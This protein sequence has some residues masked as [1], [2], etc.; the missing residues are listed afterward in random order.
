[1]FDMSKA[2]I[3]TDE[4][5]LDEDGNPRTDV[6]IMPDNILKCHPIMKDKLEQAIELFFRK[7]K[8]D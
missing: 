3:K 2:E 4:N 7:K 8:S 6:L 5:M 1:M